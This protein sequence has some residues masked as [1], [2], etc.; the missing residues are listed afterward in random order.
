MSDELKTEE[1]ANNLVEAFAGLGDM[2]K[3]L[4]ESLKELAKLVPKPNVIVKGADVKPDI[5]GGY[6]Q[7]KRNR[8]KKR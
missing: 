7:K 6:L 2:V 1:L 5:Y 4:S 8:R 3:E